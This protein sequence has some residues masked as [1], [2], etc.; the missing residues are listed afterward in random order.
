MGLT[1][2]TPIKSRG[3]E[4]QPEHPLWPQDARKEKQ[5]FDGVLS[6]AFASLDD[7]LDWCHH[8]PHP[9]GKFYALKGV[10]PSDELTRLRPGLELEQVHKLVIPQ[11][12]GE[13]H[14]VIVKQIKG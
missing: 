2:V 8:L 7:M 3:E 11:L 13:R 6:R 4:F 1:N 10:V 12:E 14:L 9:Q 5:G